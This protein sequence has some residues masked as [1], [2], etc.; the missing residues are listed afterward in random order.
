MHGSRLKSK[1]VSL[2]DASVP[3]KKSYLIPSIVCFLYGLAFS[4]GVPGFP[5]ITL[6]ICN[7]DS[8]KSAYYYGIGMTI[9]YCTESIIAPVLGT[10]SDVAGRRS[11]LLLSC[12]ACAAEYFFMALTPSIQML[13]VCRALTG[14]SD[15]GMSS[16]YTIFSDICVHNKDNLSLTFGRVQ[17][18]FFSSFIIG[19]LLGGIIIDHY[20]AETCL[21]VAAG[22]GAVA[23]VFAL[24]FLEETLGINGNV[25]EKIVYLQTG[26]YPYSP[27]SDL[28]STS[29]NGLSM[30]G[31][32]S[33][34]EADL[35]SDRRSV[36]RYIDSTPETLLAD[37]RSAPKGMHDVSDEDYACKAVRCCPSCLRRN[38]PLNWLIRFFIISNPLPDIYV[39]L[40][41]VKIRQLIFPMFLISVAVT[42]LT[43]IWYIYFDY[44]WGASSVEVGTY[45]SVSSIL[46]VFVVGYLLQ[47]IV[48]R[49]LTE[50]QAIIAGYFVSSLQYL[51]V[52]WAPTV[53]WA[54]LGLIFMIG[55]IAEPTCSGIIV[56]Q[57]F[58]GHTAKDSTARL[59]NLQGLLGSVKTVAGAVGSI[60][61][62]S[63]FR[64]SISLTPPKAWITMVVTSSSFILA[65]IY[66]FCIFQTKAWKQSN[67]GS[68]LST[69]VSSASPLSEADFVAQ[70]EIS[71]QYTALKSSDL[72]EPSELEEAE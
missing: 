55:M 47:L 59:G 64:Y 13:Y 50:K 48:P 58:I 71:E 65:S 70:S 56:K 60:L 2:D 43:S 27:S 23:C 20:G 36:E 42:G 68:R 3:A 9:R 66:T 6:R 41:N 69:D 54:Y 5:A 34:T 37:Q 51:V 25:N 14:L 63:I 40:S 35:R 18:T 19:P 46:A 45:V 44:M 15:F 8:S 53:Q 21:L 32:H 29:S 72:H 61:F 31:V 62:S 11:V 39:H 28:S 16:A 67:T 38:K 12:V 33:M 1:S 30:K 52:A 7:G 49:Y 10:L 4:L 57:S 22:I 26:K 17:A 24:F